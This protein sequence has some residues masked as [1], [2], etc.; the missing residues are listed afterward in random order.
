MGTPLEKH[1][2]TAFIAGDDT[3]ANAI[4]AKIAASAGFAPMITGGLNNARYLEAMAHRN[5]QI[6]VVQGGGT[7]AGFVYHQVRH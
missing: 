7:N 3:E 6:A 2:V 5:I 1:R 4:V